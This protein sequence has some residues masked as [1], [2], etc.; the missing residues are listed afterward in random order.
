M[1]FI[2]RVS[3]HSEIKLMLPTSVFPRDNFI[4]QLFERKTVLNSEKVLLFEIYLY[5]E[6]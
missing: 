2:P 4:L 5:I 6:R 3:L 1:F